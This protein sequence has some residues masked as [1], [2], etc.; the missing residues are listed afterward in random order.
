IYK[1]GRA[2]AIGVSNF[3]AAHLEGILA[4]CD[5]VPAVNQVEFSPFLYQKE[6]LDYCVRREIAVEAYAP[7][8]RGR[9]LDH[10]SVAEI[11]AVHARTPA[12]V[13]IRWSLQKGCIPLPKSVHRERIL[14][15]ADVFG[16]EL[17][18]GQMQVLDSL[19][20]GFRVAPDP[21]QYE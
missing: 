13:L 19:D 14:E 18:A 9:R 2:G 7:I 8:T 1:E 15:N 3:T 4:E 20:E 6:L 12:Q 21:N 11:A 17:E 16:F 10:P 5:V